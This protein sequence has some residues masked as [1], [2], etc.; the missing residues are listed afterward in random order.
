[1]LPVVLGAGGVAWAQT[2]PLPF[3]VLA[4]VGVIALGIGGFV[5]VLLRMPAPPIGIRFHPDGRVEQLD[6]T[7]ESPWNVVWL[8]RRGEL[9][10]YAF[11]VLFLG[12][13]VALIVWGIAA[14]AYR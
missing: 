8:G 3:S 6:P 13:M 7:T 12:A 11:T 4:G 9:A 14:G 5:V 10:L 1:M 2:L